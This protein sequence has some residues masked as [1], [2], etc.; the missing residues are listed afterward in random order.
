MQ[1][2]LTAP[3]LC[4]LSALEKGNHRAKLSSMV[5]HD[6]N[7]IRS[8]F[9]PNPRAPRAPE[10]ALGDADQQR[11]GVVKHEVCFL[12]QLRWKYGVPQG[13]FFSAKP[14]GQ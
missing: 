7:K 6:E 5:P 8:R 2:I 12:D 14:T 10:G 13:R 9:L 11:V 1:R 4:W 3:Q